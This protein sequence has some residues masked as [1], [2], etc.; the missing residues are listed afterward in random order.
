[1][2]FFDYFKATLFFSCEYLES[3]QVSTNQIFRVRS[4]QKNIR[5]NTIKYEIRKKTSTALF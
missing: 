1:M 2:D 5:Y 3:V 4:A